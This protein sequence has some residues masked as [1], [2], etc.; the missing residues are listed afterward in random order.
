VLSAAG[1]P[2][3]TTQME[4]TGNTAYY[5]ADDYHQQYLVGRCRLNRWNPH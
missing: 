2:A 5:F 1:K 4:P 3:I